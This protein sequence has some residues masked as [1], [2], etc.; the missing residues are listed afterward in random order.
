MYHLNVLGKTFL[1]ISS[2]RLLAS[3]RKMEQTFGWNLNFLDLKYRFK[4]FLLF[5]LA[6]VSPWSFPHC[7]FLIISWLCV[8]RHADNAVMNGTL[9]SDITH[10]HTQP[11]N[12]SSVV[13]FTSHY[14]HTPV[15]VC[16]YI[17]P[18]SQAPWQKTATVSD[19]NVPWLAE[20]PALLLFCCCF[21]FLKE[22]QAVICT[23]KKCYVEWHENKSC[24]V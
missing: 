6:L 15:C 11:Q 3:G 2:F 19:Q 16:V 5:N 24:C 13:P 12:K 7:F 8:V 4:K 10:T 9:F 23:E 22:S 21:F 17:K 20:S 14:L 1:L 18:Q